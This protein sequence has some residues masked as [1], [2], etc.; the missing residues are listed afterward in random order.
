MTRAAK[1]KARTNE[2]RR[3]S[4]LANLYTTLLSKALTGRGLVTIRDWINKWFVRKEA[5]KGLSEENYTSTDKQRVADSITKE[6]LDE[7]IFE[8]D[9]YILNDDEI[10][11]LLGVAE[12]AEDFIALLTDT[13][14]VM[15]GADITLDSPV[16]IN[17]D[18]TIE[19]NGCTL[20]GTAA[21][22]TANLFTVNGGRL[23]LKGPGAINVNGR[24]AQANNGAEVVVE[25][26][27]YETNDVAFTAGKGG[28]VTMN[29]GTIKAVEGGIIAP[30]GGGEIEVNGGMIDVSDNFAVGTNGT[31][32]RGGNVITI[33]GG[34][35]IGNISSAGYE[36]IGVYIPNSD[37]LIMNGGTIQANGGAGICMR[38]GNVTI[39]GGEIIATTGD[40]VPGWIGDKKTQMNASG[41]IYHESA[42][43]PGKAGMSLTVNDGT[44]TG[45]EHSIEV[46]SNEAVPNVTV[47]DGDFTPAYPEE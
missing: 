3:K 33:N 20:T 21:S 13:D 27:S 46:L 45:A 29:G 6:E 19:L 2:E 34:T 12:S 18:L 32:G 14:A 23:T 37:T 16:A 39:N 5:G 24:I 26:G 36:A 31:A 4:A 35:L 1:K 17:A 38:A 22:K 25:S 28:K 44:I 47:I 11:R 7:A 9:E 42:D 40:H 10:N 43:Y 8:N 15:L 30:E 41:I